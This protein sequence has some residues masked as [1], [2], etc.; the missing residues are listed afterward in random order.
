MPTG[1]DPSLLYPHLPPN[2]YI[3]HSS[4][5]GLPAFLKPPLH[6]WFLLPGMPFPW[7]SA[8]PLLHLLLNATRHTW[9]FTYFI[10]CLST[11][12]MKVM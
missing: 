7:V 8:W 12:E 10:H 2:P 3:L 1:F 9:H 5:T 11:T 4:R 6:L